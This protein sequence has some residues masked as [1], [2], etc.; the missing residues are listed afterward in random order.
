MGQHRCRVFPSGQNVVLEGL[1]YPF[2][3][4]S[5]LE[6]YHNGLTSKVVPPF[7]SLQSLQMGCIKSQPADDRS[8][9]LLLSHVHQYKGEELLPMAGT[10]GFGRALGAGPHSLTY[11][12]GSQP[13]GETALPS[14]AFGCCTALSRRGC[15]LCF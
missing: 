14:Q 3:M 1:G 6:I 11:W 8:Q 4:P 10:R 9:H 13:C 12:P 7:L 15:G 5:F 2:R